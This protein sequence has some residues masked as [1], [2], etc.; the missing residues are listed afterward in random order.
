M[1]LEG[2]DHHES[3]GGYKNPEDGW[4]NLLIGE[5][6]E[7]YTRDNNSSVSVRIP[8]QTIDEDGE[9][10]FSTFETCILPSGDV[11]ES[12][13]KKIGCI[14]KV[15][16]LLDS[17]NEKLPDD[18]LV[19]D[20]Q[21]V[22]ALAMKLPGKKVLARTEVSTYKTKGDNPVEKTQNNIMEIKIYAGP[23]NGGASKA[24]KDVAPAEDKW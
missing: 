19:S 20:Q 18:C 24:K 1:K 23:I 8:W 3:F 16:G 10:A 13:E 17:F 14:L 21:F 15:T 5:G 11:F 12:W 4:H 22:D 7:R 2:Q 6:I 9:L